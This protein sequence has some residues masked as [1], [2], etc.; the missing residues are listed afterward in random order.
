MG[1]QTMAD[2]SQ[3]LAWFVEQHGKRETGLLAGES[4]QMLADRVRAGKAAE[5]ALAERRLWDA[6]KTA[7]LYAWQARET[8]NG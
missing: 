3:F 8:S 6:Q 4:D 1:V 5:A 2:R 7:A